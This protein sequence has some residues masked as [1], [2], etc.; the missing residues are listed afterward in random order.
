MLGSLFLCL[1]EIGYLGLIFVEIEC[2]KILLFATLLFL[3]APS[4]YSQETNNGKRGTIKVRKTGQLVKVKYD[5]VNY[6]LIGIDRYGNVIDTAV[7]EFQMSVSIQ[8][9]FHKFNV[10][11]FAL[12]NEMRQLLE[13]TGGETQLFFKN[14]KVKDR[15]GAL[16][17]MPDIQYTYG[18]WYK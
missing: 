1:H 16:L 2:M 3:I 12:T 14:I 9:V 11:G 4:A 10:V 17:K 6:R 8:G 7:V 18:K 13:R 15:Y 5:E